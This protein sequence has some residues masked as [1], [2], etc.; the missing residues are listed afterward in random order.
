MW[1]VWTIAIIVV[2]NAAL[3]MI[4]VFYQPRDIAAT[5]AWLLVLLLLPVIGLALYWI[6]GRKLSNQKLAA[7]ATQKRLGIDEMVAAQQEA[8]AVGQNLIGQQELAGVPELVRSLLKSDNALVTTM[9]D[10]ELIFT[11]AD[12]LK[13]I[14]VDLEAAKDHIH[15]E[16]YAL[17]PDD[18]G[19]QVRD[20]LAQKARA[21][22][23]V[24]V[25]YDAFGSHRLNHKFWQPVIQAGGQVEA[26]FATKLARANPRINF[27]NH[28]KSL[29]IDGKIGYLGGFD[30]GRSK[31]RFQIT[32]D[33][34][35]RIQ[36]QAVAV[37]QARFFMD[38][39][40]TAKIKKVHFQAAYF[41]QPDDYGDVTMQVVSSGPEQT[42]ETLKLA[43]LRMF[44][45][46]KTSILVQSPY[47]VPDDSLLDALIIA[48]NAGIDVQVMIPRHS[49]QPLMTAA[50]RFYLD[51][52]VAGGG[53]VFYYEG[54][55]LHTK[56]V[57]IDGRILATGTANMDIRS[58]K[59][60]FEQAA[61]LYA[62]NLAKQVVAQYQID[63]IKAT[64][65][66]M[67]A[68]TKRSGHSRLTSEWARLL[69]PIL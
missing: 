57:I 60:N 39:N 53:K 23:K 46:A 63:L 67:A 44:A 15:L 42:H 68:V 69:A 48:V 26:F 58:F 41:P 21:G 10:V 32:R 28:R 49:N 2:I 12:Y 37:M 61:V 3:A 47:F 6:F 14:F 62:P 11:Q 56:A 29:V 45:Q 36:G 35:L 34:D 30:L 24:R 40:T 18:I 38:W 65:Y 33:L 7:L 50:S 31:K 22:V 66:T 59:L 19:L 64:P 20:I 43:Y 27:R 54:G 51:R 8:I 9:N 16:I 1:L 52:V 55:F 5:W 13:A 17:A 4:T 25:M